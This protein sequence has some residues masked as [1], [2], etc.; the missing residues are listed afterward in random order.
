[1]LSTPMVCVFLLD[2][3]N[4]NIHRNLRRFEIPDGDDIV[5]YSDFYDTQKV[6]Q[7]CQVEVPALLH[8]LYST[9]TQKQGRSRGADTQMS[10][11]HEHGVQRSEEELALALTATE[12]TFITEFLEVLHFT[13]MFSQVLRD[14][15]T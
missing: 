1:M 13:G 14:Y 2:L 8:S 11:S 6:E 9:V 4:E 5:V 7:R 12:L 10:R 3:V 15:G